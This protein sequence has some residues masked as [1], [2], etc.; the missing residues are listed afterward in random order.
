MKRTKR[1]T[2]DTKDRRFQ[3]ICNELGEDT[4]RRLHEAYTLTAAA[5]YRRAKDHANARLR[6]EGSKQEN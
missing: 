2:I 6:E 3:Q 1:S 4:V 5:L